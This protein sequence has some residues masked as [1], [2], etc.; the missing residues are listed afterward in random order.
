MNIDLMNEFIEFSKSLNVSAAAKSLFVSQSTL[1]K[2]L[3]ALEEEVGAQLIDRSP[4]SGLRLTE[5][6]KVFLDACSLISHSYDVA[7]ENC[8]KLSRSPKKI[9]I[10]RPCT[11]DASSELIYEVYRNMQK[12]HDDISVSLLQMG[13]YS[14]IENLTMG[15]VDC[16][17]SHIV[18]PMQKAELEAKNVSLIPLLEDD[19]YVWAQKDSELITKE[20]LYV[21]DLIDVPIL[22]PASRIYM[23]L[24]EWY[25]F[26]CAKAGFKPLLA[27]RDVNDMY[28]LMNTNLK[29]GIMVLTSEATMGDPVFELQSNLALRPFED[30]DLKNILYLAF[31]KDND[32]PALQVLIDCIRS[33]EYPVF[34]GKSV[35]DIIER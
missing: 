15:R 6:G 10:L 2:H 19:V 5:A 16:T 14:M 32:N 33:H 27:Y 30:N 26:L 4:A 28:E 35:T 1:S 34:K 12:D 11:I 29:H 22:V 25:T 20:H 9:S 7:L 21:R 13:G 31:M 3:K 8:H 18:S 24:H 17:T 23:D